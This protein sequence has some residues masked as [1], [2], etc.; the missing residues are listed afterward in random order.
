[1][2]YWNSGTAP[3][4]KNS[5]LKKPYKKEKLT[6]IKNKYIYIYILKK[7]GTTQE[8]KQTKIFKTLSTKY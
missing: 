7:K 5:V 1:M 3:V 4:A 8:R 6:Q 2:V